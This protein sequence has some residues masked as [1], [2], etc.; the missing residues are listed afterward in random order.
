MV[1]GSY[2]LLPFF[3]AA[4][5]FFGCSFRTN[6]L[7]H[8]SKRS[9]PGAFQ[10][11]DASSERRDPWTTALQFKSKVSL[12]DLGFR[13][14]KPLPKGIYNLVILCLAKL[15]KSFT[16]LLDQIGHGLFLVGRN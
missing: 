15:G 14:T 2:I 10:T 4:N 13:P 11:F 9:F 5:I 6:G 3:S 1:S 12:V 16:V 7:S 8:T